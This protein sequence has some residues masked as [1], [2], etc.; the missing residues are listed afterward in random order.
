MCFPQTHLMT[1]YRNCMKQ[2]HKRCTRISTFLHLTFI[3]ITLHCFAGAVVKAQDTVTGAF[4]GIVTDSQSGVRL[5][6]ALVEIIN[7]Q[8]R[9]TYTLR[10]DYRGR[11]FQ[12][13]LLPG[14]YTVRVSLTGYQTKEAAQI[15]R[16]T[17]TGEVVPVPVALD[18]LPTG[19]AAP[20]PANPLSVE[21]TDTRANISTI[22]GRRTGSFTESE[23]VK[24]P[25]GGTTTTRTFD[26]LA[27]LLPG[28]APPP[29]TIGSIA[30]PGVG[31]GVGSS[32]QFSA[33]GLR[34]R[35]NN[36]TVDGSDNNDEDIGVRR[37]G[38]VDLIPQSIESV[39]EYNAITLL[40]P[41]QFG[42]NI[43]AQVNAV[44]KSG[45]ND[46]HGVVY[47]TFNSSQLNARNFFDTT[48]GNGTT[49]QSINN[50]D[51][52]VQTRSVSGAVLSQQP[53][54]VRN[55]SGGEDSL[56]FSQLG[57]V[58]GGPLKQNQL[59]YFV[60][61][62]T[63]NLNATQEASFAVP[64]IEERG[65]FRSGATGIFLDPFTGQPT[66]TIPTSRN[67]AAIFS[68]YP[69]PNNVTGIYGANTYTQT[70][71][72]SGDGTILSGK[73]DNNFH[74][75]GREQSFTGRYNFADD[76]RDIPVTGG[77]LFSSLKPKIRTQN[78]SLFLNSN[79]SASN[80]VKSVF[81]QVRL[82]YGRTRLRFDE[83][84]DHE[85]LVPSRL[86]PSTP[87]L[88][89][90]PELLNVTAPL[91]PGIGNNG[92]VIYV[93]RPITV[94]DEIGPV[95]QVIIEGFSPVGVDVFNFPQR[96]V[97]N[98]YQ[99]A[100]QLTLRAR[101]HSIVFGVDVRRTELNSELPRNARPQLTF[102]GAPR[103]VFENGIARFP[104]ANDSNP[105]IRGQD[106]ASIAT[107]NNFF[108]TL[109]TGAPDSIN[110]RFYQLNVFAQDQWR[111]SPN[112]SLSF[113][114]RYEYNTPLKEINGLVE[115]TFASPEL[116]LI[117]GLESFI[118][119]RTRI[120][121]PDRNNFGPRVG[122]AYSP[123]PFSSH[124]LTVVR[125]GYGIFYDQI[126][127]AVASQSRNAFPNFLTLN[128]GGGPFTS[129]ENEFPLALY[130]PARDSV[131][132][133]NDSVNLQVPGSLNILNPN[134]PLSTYLPYLLA[135]FPSAISP[136][137]PARLLPMPMAHHYSV[138]VEQQL[139]RSIAVSAAYVGTKGRHLLRFSTPNLGPALNITPTRFD[140]FPELFSIP[141]F[142][143][144]VAQPAR[145][146]SGVGAINIFETTARSSY[147]ALQVQIRGRSFAGFQYQL[148][149]TLSKAEDDVSDVFDLAGASA[150]PQNSLTFAGEWGAA[151]FDS[152]NRVSY[153][154]IYTAPAFTTRRGVVAAVVRGIEIGS[155]GQFQTG[156]PFT[157]NSTIDVNQDGNLTDRLDN[158]D[159]LIV[160]GDARQPLMLTTSNTL[161]LLAPFGQDGIVTRNSFRAGRT[162]E[163]NLS[164][165]KRF[166]VKNQFTLRGDCFNCTNQANFGIP[167]RFLEAPGFGRAINAITP[168]RRVQLS[169][170]YSF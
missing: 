28:V 69:F 67:G 121:D 53:L 131:P 17:Y 45:G 99:F 102:N 89:N 60:S 124:H 1:S 135:N 157:V 70:L 113:G 140:I 79:L 46:I 138:A 155:T 162:F 32:G 73:I 169:V 112:V 160:T 122:G 165:A 36:F 18:A 163:L 119:G 52:L 21:D 103:L 33:N 110:L 170:K 58:V 81:N 14:T 64:T 85:F 137:L 6:G 125:G 115:R 167:V 111:V 26:E 59:F 149:Y 127:G 80:A 106:L 139:W 129:I 57:F 3:S 48:F 133:G 117:P 120:N 82:S 40:A 29:Q 136:T 7:Q 42:R 156:R 105:I 8:T 95:G 12:G 22:D 49:T 159:G 9:V 84:R 130:N 72:A 19:T 78:L 27:L 104:T 146:V 83:I 158:T 65:A 132:V 150:L 126:L 50:E 123:N 152:R 77:A 142:R 148:A 2:R 128:F 101:S 96:R 62:E 24:L 144:R 35:G 43:G 11:F 108:L 116:S 74:V 154:F 71:P 90:A 66:S 153:N 164:V 10:T 134:L 161:S 118:A 91:A 94:E 25:I 13:L 4:E 114:L 93:S 23:I 92:P 107:P 100:D 54:T 44:S 88:L 56:T 141:R 75:R 5:R 145:P 34:S 68:L 51:V 76:S 168:A 37:Q 86:F 166:G 15:L 20:A 39:Q 143:G 147:N 47:G 98:T 30:G 63:E 151:N 16:I 55:Q 41:A 38:F 61:L 109:S 87:F 97:N 31:A